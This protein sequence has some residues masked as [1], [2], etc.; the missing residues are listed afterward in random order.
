MLVGA[1]L[2]A[3]AGVDAQI[4]NLPIIPSV[5]IPVSPQALEDLEEYEIPT[6]E[7]LRLLGLS[8]E[9]I[10]VIYQ[11]LEAAE[12]PTSIEGYEATQQN[13]R[14]PSTVQGD[15]GTGGTGVDMTSLDQPDSARVDSAILAR[16]EII[17]GHATLRSPLRTYNVEGPVRAPAH[18]VIKPGDEVTITAY[19]GG[20]DFQGVYTVDDAG[21]IFQKEA[22]RVYVKGMTFADAR[23]LLRNR[24]GRF[25]DLRRA[26]FDMALTYSPVIRVN[27]VG[28][29]E[30]PGTYTI[31]SWNGAINAIGFASGPTDL[32]S[33]RR[34]EVRRGGETIK[35]L[36]VYKFLM[37]PASNQDFFLE[38]NDYLVVPPHGKLVT[39]AGEVNRPHQYELLDSEHLASLVG[40]AGGLR[41]TAY[42]ENV[43]VQ[44]YTGSKRVILNVDY[45]SL[46]TWGG[47][48]ELADGDYV[49]LDTL[50]SE[51]ENFVEVRGD[52]NFP[53][54]YE[55]RS[56]DRVRDILRKAQGTANYDRIDQA[57]LIR[58][59]EDFTP[60]YIPIDIGLVLDDPSSEDN[61]LLEERDVIEVIGKD[62]TVED[63]TVNVDGA[64]KNP[65]E[66][67]YAKGMTLK[68]LLF[69]A[70][71][72]RT[73]AALD[74]IEIA[75]VVEY[76]ASA[77]AFVPSTDTRIET[78]SVGFDLQNDPSAE[79]FL[80]QPYDQIYVHLA[81]GF[82]FQQK[83]R[84]VGE[85]RFPGI[86]TLK[87]R[88]E[89]IVDLLER[90]GGLT[91]TAF[92]EG[93]SMFRNGGMD[94]DDYSRMVLELDKALKDPGS[95]YNHLLL[96]GDSIVIPKLMDYVALSGF[97]YNPEVDTISSVTVPFEKGKRAGYY[98][99]QFGGGFDDRAKKNRTLVIEPNG[100]VL[101]T[102]EILWINIYPKVTTEGARI[103][104]VEK[105]RPETR[106]ADQARKPFDWNLFASTLSAGI[107][108]FATIYALIS[109][110]TSN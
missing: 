34:I 25:M 29:V 33:V 59:D 82:D 73:E 91:S 40:Y 85:V 49:Y 53:G 60:R 56:G 108:S 5:N 8:E 11:N 48:F 97:M 2:V 32:A 37:D 86:Y 55:L 104:A 4:D 101:R 19:G 92:V 109:R 95:H 24:F 45:D 61:V 18:Y 42:R 106:Y 99:N 100:R 14:E 77:N 62:H 90:A 88:E 7:E 27:I 64:V 58:L 16:P 87:S 79:E 50:P 44:R 69:Y 51:F 13:L 93:A 1:V 17:Y 6:R 36:D 9:E 35:I 105:D 10:D 31:S 28:E 94:Y 71:G 83:V 74:R 43:Q 78:V 47:Q 75:R 70:G 102:K 39:V 65:G 67:T 84:I 26:K 46:I 52:V 57:Y 103:V 12:D 107:L 22:G 96:E 54:P 89:S 15:G 3:A 20:I 68:D 30:K 76:D 41:P 38:D 98:V 23:N 110:N 81:E 80:L 63:Y 21:H 66:F 72:P